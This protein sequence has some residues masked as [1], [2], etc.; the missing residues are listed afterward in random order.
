MKKKNPTLGIL[1]NSGS[2]L[3]RELDNVFIPTVGN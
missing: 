2:S 1:D 3:P